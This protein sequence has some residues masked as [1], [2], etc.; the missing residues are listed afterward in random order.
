MTLAQEFHKACLGP[1]QHLDAAEEA[2][3]TGRGIVSGAQ[4][5]PVGLEMRRKGHGRWRLAG[6][7]G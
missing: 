6:R 3:D 7:G 5:Y 1:K 4:F 2:L